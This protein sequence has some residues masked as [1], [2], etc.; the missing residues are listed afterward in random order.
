MRSSARFRSSTPSAA[1][2]FTSVPMPVTLTVT[3]PVGGT[4]SDTS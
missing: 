1:N 3:A 4:V 2:A